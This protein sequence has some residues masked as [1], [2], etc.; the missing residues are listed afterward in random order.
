MA[1][2]GIYIASFLLFICRDSL[3]A[4]DFSHRQF[5]YD[6]AILFLSN[7]VSYSL[8]F[9]AYSV[10][11]TDYVLKNIIQRL[12]APEKRD[13]MIYFI[14]ASVCMSLQ[15][16]AISF[17][18]ITRKRGHSYS[19]GWTRWWSIVIFL[20][21][22]IIGACAC[23]MNPASVYLNS[24]VQ[25][26]SIVMVLVQFFNAFIASWNLWNLIQRP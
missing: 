19:H 12:D 25:R 15:Q 6:L 17:H 11:Y 23:S 14:T 21:A 4:W 24:S 3:L 18:L 5:Q 7:V 9:L 2:L 20:L 26:W 16:V 10:Y 8:Y 13:I 1:D 22:C